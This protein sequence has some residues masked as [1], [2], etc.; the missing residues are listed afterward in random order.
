MPLHHVQ[1]SAPT[2]TSIA[3]P[4]QATH[5]GE[6]AASSRTAR[7]MTTRDAQARRAAH[8]PRESPWKPRRY[9]GARRNG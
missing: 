3:A 6:G 5:S 9:P 8:T 4:S 7:I 1:S 2:P